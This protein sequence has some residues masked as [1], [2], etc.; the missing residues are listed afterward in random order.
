MIKE[1]NSIEEIQE[2]YDEES[3]TYVFTKD[4][5]YIDVV[6]FNFNLN[7]KANIKARNIIAM[8]ITAKDIT[9]NDISARDINAWNI[10]ALEIKADSIEAND[11]RYYAVCF[12]YY[13]IKCKTIQ[14]FRENDKH[15]VL[16]GKIE[17]KNTSKQA[18]EHI[19]HMAGWEYYNIQE[20]I[21]SIEKD[22]EVLE[23]LETL[24][25]YYPPF[26]E[27]LEE[28]FE[29]GHNEDLTKIKEWLENDK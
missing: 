20:D 25:K 7:V 22:L 14:G 23:Q 21:P 24:K 5:V 8:D 4:N 27:F 19:K 15:F 29:K 16:D 1:F 9:A 3:N 12:A 6:K 13:E 11:I 2:Y 28:M 26:R 10:N 18:L 17:V